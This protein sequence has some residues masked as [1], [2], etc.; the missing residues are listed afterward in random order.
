MLP[1]YVQNCFWSF[2]LKELDLDLNK[3]RI[4]LNVLNLG[5]LEALKWLFSQYSIKHIKSVLIDYGAKGE[6]SAK[7]LNYW[8]LI[9]GVDSK[10]LKTNR[11]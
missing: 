10:E 3:R 4:I 9:L 5:S 8:G 1:I 7:A 6:L 2:D 11:F